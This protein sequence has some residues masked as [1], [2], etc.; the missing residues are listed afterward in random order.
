VKKSRDLSYL[1]ANE[2]RCEDTHQIPQQTT[3]P[4]RFGLIPMFPLFCNKFTSKMQQKT[5]TGA[6]HCAIFSSLI[7]KPFNN[8]EQRHPDSCNA[9]LHKSVRKMPNDFVQSRHNATKSPRSIL[10]TQKSSLIHESPV[11]RAE[12]SAATLVTA[13]SP[14]RD[15]P[16]RWCENIRP[17]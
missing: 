4:Y 9:L 6:P 5:T 7:E 16:S 2:N 10:A 3:S 1:Q 17:A 12:C 8:A 11:P 13:C 14:L 15:H